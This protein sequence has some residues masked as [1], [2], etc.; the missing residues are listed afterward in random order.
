MKDARVVQLRKRLNVAGDK[1]SPDYDDAV[2]EAV[3]AFQMGAG[4]GV[5]GMLGPTPCTP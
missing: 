3:K 5:D 4:I 1:D 2:F